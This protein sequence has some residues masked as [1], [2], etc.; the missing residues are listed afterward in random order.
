MRIAQGVHMANSSNIPQPSVH[1]VPDPKPGDLLTA[2]D[3]ASRTG[4]H[5][6]TFANW[7][8]SGKGPAFLRLGSAIRYRWSDV[9]AWLS[10]QRRVSTSD[11]GA[12]V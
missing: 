4:L 8:V 11:P 9:E 5:P 6:S 7:R 12:E 1:A 10:S 2:E 3:L